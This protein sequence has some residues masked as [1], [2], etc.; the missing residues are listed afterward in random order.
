MM[1]VGVQIF[2]WLSNLSHCYCALGTTIFLIETALQPDDIR[3]S[4]IKA[5]L[6]EHCLC[7]YV[8]GIDAWDRT[9]AWGQH[10]LFMGHLAPS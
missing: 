9:V 5:S 4:Y 6:G 1:T 7:V 2:L 8:S 3:T 10:E